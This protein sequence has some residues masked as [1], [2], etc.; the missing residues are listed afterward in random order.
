MFGTKGLQLSFICS[1]IFFLVIQLWACKPQQINHPVELD[2]EAL[3]FSKSVVQT[4]FDKDCDTYYGMLSPELFAL[5]GDGLIS[6]E[7]LADRYCSNVEKA[8]RDNEK[9]FTDYIKDFELEV[10]DIPT[11]EN[12][13]NMKMPDYYSADPSDFLFSGSKRRV[14]SSSM[15]I[16]D[17]MFLFLVRKENGKWVVKGG[18]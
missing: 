13:Y 12:K 3:A 11:L 2:K 15:Y 1:T 14:E 9:N 8:I 10:I 18:I 5:D 6:K 16:W 4:Y 7:S 17:D